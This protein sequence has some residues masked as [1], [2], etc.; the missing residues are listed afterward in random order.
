MWGRRDPSA[1]FACVIAAIGTNGAIHGAADIRFSTAVMDFAGRI[2]ANP[3]GH[4]MYV[5][6][7]RIYSL[8][9]KP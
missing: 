6:A 1:F 5:T 7:L 4:H 3:A 2:P 9:K 8:Q